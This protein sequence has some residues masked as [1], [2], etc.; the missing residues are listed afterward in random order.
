MVFEKLNSE[1][2]E[3]Y[4]DYLKVAV[5]EEPDVLMTYVIDE[6]GIKSRVDNSFFNTV[7]ILA[8][9]DGKIVGRIEYHFYGCIQDG[10]KMAYVDWV[11]VLKSYRHKGI[12]QQLFAE[13]EK[14]CAK[15]GINEYFLIRATNDDADRFYRHF[16]N[17]ELSESPILRKY[18]KK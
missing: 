4:I 17:A 1:N 12:A 16:T 13:F 11:Y 3:Q 7:N 9:T 6:E 15:K 18:F 10:Y 5:Q 14:D 8:K 2:V